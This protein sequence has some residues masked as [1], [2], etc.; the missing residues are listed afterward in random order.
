MEVGGLGIEAFGCRYQ[1]EKKYWWI[2]MYK[3]VGDF[4]S[5]CEVCQVYS[6]I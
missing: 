1:N 3:D 6:N 5:S 2:A 4:V